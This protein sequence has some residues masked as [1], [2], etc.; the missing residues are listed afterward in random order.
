MEMNLKYLVEV[1]KDNL[2][3]T[4][5]LTSTFFQF[6]EDKLSVI[7]ILPFEVMHQMVN[8]INKLYSIIYS[9]K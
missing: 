2:F 6:Q 3:K 1:R 4:F 7:Q 9:L 5:H 8:G